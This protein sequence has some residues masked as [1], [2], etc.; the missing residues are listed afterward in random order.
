ME[1]L[2]I[3]ACELNK[4]EWK[5]LSPD[6]LL[7]DLC[8]ETTAPP[9]PSSAYL[10]LAEYEAGNVE[11]VEK[12]VGYNLAWSTTRHLQTRPESVVTCTVHHRVNSNIGETVFCFCWLNTDWTSEVMLSAASICTSVASKLVQGICSPSFA[13][14]VCTRHSNRVEKRL[15]LVGS[16]G[17]MLRFDDI[18]CFVWRFFASVVVD[19]S[20][21]QPTVRLTWLICGYCVYTERN[22][23]N[24]R[25]QQRS[26]FHLAEDLASWMF[27]G[28]LLCAV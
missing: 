12:E 26:K 4:L 2:Y 10:F 25:R 11:N 5:S 1:H 8:I 18:C 27:P 22:Y 13:T 7:D 19:R 16:L 23:Q 14:P 24:T 9:T 20:P 3:E 28:F 15:L 6:R 21:P 17:H